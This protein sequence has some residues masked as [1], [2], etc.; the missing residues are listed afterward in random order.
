MRSKVLMTVLAGCSV[1]AAGS[2]M[3]QGSRAVPKNASEAIVVNGRSAAVT[4]LEITSAKGEKVGTLKKALEP[5]KRI[6]FKFRPRNGCVFTIAASFADDA[7]FEPTEQDLCI[8]K[9]I[10]F[11]D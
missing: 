4:G 3:A 2:A 9:T 7:E 11:T 10:R 5:G 8:D 1:L 6:A